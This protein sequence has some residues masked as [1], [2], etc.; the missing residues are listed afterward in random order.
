M[1][2][3]FA[4][5]PQFPDGQQAE[6]VVYDGRDTGTVVCPNADIKI[7]ITASPEVR[8]MR[9]HKEFLAKGMDSDYEDVLAQTKE[10]DL[11]D[12]SRASAPL[13]PADDAIIIDTSD[14]AIEDVFNRVCKVIDD[15]NR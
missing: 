6:G 11:R 5:N 10:R 8:A 12:A 7:F 14:L 13:K 9:R 1:Q 2:Q 3:D 15:K 4:L